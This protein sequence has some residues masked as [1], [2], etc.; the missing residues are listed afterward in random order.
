VV[1]RI[2]RVR[3]NGLI[4]MIEARAVRRVDQRRVITVARTQS[5]GTGSWRQSRVDVASRVREIDGWAS[6]WGLVDGQEL[7]EVVDRH[8]VRVGWDS[9]SGACSDSAIRAAV[10]RH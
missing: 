6:R 4:L 7:T 2:A 10:S 8:P 3:V 9:Q 5:R 1:S